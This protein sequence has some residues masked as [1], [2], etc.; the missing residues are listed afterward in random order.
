MRLF[1]HGIGLEQI[2]VARIETAA[3]EQ[4][5]HPRGDPREHDADLVVGRRGQRPELQCP[6]GPS[7]KTPS[8]S[9]VWT[10]RFRFVRYFYVSLA[11]IAPRILLASACHQPVM[12]TVP[13]HEDHSRSANPASASTRTCTG[14]RIGW[15]T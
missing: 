4:P 10:C 11:V 13:V 12:T 9:S 8:N 7:K 2:G 5:Q 3:L 6:S 1:D 14:S 15:A